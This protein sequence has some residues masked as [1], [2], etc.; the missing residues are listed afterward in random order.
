MNH[1]ALKGSDNYAYLCKDRQVCNSVFKPS[2]FSIIMTRVENP[3]T[4]Y[5]FF[6]FH[7]FA[8]WIFRFV[9][10]VSVSTLKGIA[11][12]IINSP[13]VHTTSRIS[14]WRFGVVKEIMAS[15][16]FW[17][18]GRVVA[19]NQNNNGKRNVNALGS[20]EYGAKETVKTRQLTFLQSDT[21]LT[22][23]PICYFSFYSW[24]HSIHSC[25]H[26]SALSWFIE[27]KMFPIKSQK[28]E[29]SII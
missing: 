8:A 11:G 9:S 26:R 28:N 5:P 6:Y 24:K 20:V 4:D 10:R 1:V 22:S 13:F 3:F 21:L 14:I 29:Y 27:E 25:Q 16:F 23:Y 2:L 18:R 17:R 15:I 19:H 12:T 7:G